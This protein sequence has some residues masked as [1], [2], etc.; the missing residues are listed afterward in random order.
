[1]TWLGKCDLVLGKVERTAATI[2]G[3]LA[4]RG[5]EK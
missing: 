3:L 5:R 1:V 4:G 2:V